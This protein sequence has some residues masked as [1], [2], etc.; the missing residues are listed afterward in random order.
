M[1]SI[2]TENINGQEVQ[3]DAFQKLFENDKVFTNY[4][5]LNPALGFV[6]CGS[7]LASNLRFY[8][9]YK[10]GWGKQPGDPDEAPE[11]RIYS[12]DNPLDPIAFVIKELFPSVGGT[13]TTSV[14]RDK[15]IGHR[16]L[17]ANRENQL[18]A[19]CKSNQKEFVRLFMLNKDMLPDKVDFSIQ[20]PE[21]EQGQEKRVAS[22]FTKLS[23]SIARRLLVDFGF[24]FLPQE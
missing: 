24:C 6:F 18:K 9:N 23:Q 12:L 15:N 4:P 1:N 13:L 14:E 8:G 22:P 16:L 10:F 2:V 20:I 17:N 11:H 3:V 7:S 5:E 21:Q 19:L